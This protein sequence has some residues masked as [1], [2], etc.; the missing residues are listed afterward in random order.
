MGGVYISHLTTLIR[1]YTYNVNIY[2]RLCT[3]K[4]TI[5]ALFSLLLLPNSVRQLKA[6]ETCLPKRNKCS[7][8]PQRRFAFVIILKFKTVHNICFLVFDFLLKTLHYQ[9]FRFNFIV[10]PHICYCDQSKLFS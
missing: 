6:V 7:I 4:D 5:F 3:L 8:L 1:M 2:A 9:G 10:L